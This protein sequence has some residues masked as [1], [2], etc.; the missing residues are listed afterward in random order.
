ME[1]VT[2][3]NT[4]T[5]TSYPA[6]HA[7]HAAKWLW[8]GVWI[9]AAIA[10]VVAIGLGYI[11][12]SGGAGQASIAISAPKLV[13]EPGDTRLLFSIAPDESEARFIIQETLVGNP[14]TVVGVTHQVAGDMLID[15]KNP[16]RSVLGVIRVNVR[17]LETDNEFRNRA[18]RGQILQAERP[19]FEFA[20]FTP[21]ALA[22]LPEDITIGQ[23]FTF[24][25]LGSLNLHGVS[26]DV[27]F[28]V[29]VTPVSDTQISG[30][31]RTRL[32][33]ADFGMSIPEA[34]GV[35]DVSDTVQIE[36]DMTAQTAAAS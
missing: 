21:A 13:L 4:S 36:I 20:E 9:A 30:T 15:F 5:N 26:R 11:W 24:Q 10:L 25:L 29:T 12:V 16:A 6:A 32:S 28:D 8:V 22:G 33:Y 27:T 7:P 14:K 1:N 35:A 3:R 31:A 2:Q 23:P 17:T 34:P 18:L 19:E